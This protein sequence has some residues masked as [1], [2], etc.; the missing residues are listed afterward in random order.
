MIV[1]MVVFTMS[2]ECSFWK[3]CIIVNEI[4]CSGCSFQHFD[5]IDVNNNED[6]AL[7]KEDYFELIQHKRKSKGGRVAL[8][9]PMR[10][11][12]LRKLKPNFPEIRT[13][14]SKNIRSTIEID[15]ETIDYEIKCDGAFKYK[16]KHIFYELKGYGDGSNDILSAITA[17]QLLKEDITFKNHRFYFMGINGANI[18]NKSGVTRDSFFDPKSRKVT[19]YTKWA[20]NKGFIKFY[21]ILDIADFLEDM[22][23]YLNE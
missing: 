8:D 5:R 13:L 16:S 17:S 18:K 4:G 1:P 14:E 22:T 20:E 12:V 7:L 6:L 21:G 23:N 2:G 15:D 9:A 3:K 11:L 10:N 19:P